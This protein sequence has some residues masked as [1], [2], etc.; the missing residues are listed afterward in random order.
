MGILKLIGWDK[1][2]R[3]LK[4]ETFQARLERHVKVATQLNAL[5][6]EGAIKRAIS[7][8]LKPAN[9]MVTRMLKGSTKAL[10]DSGQLFGS[11]TGVAEKWDRAIIGVLKSRRVKKKGASK[12]SD[13]KQIAAILFYGATITV[14]PKMRRYFY[15]RSQED[16]VR[17]KPIKKTTTVIVI[18]PRPYL[19]AALDKAMIAQYRVNWDAA[20]AKALAGGLG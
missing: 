2:R 19:E 1:L 12:S 16:P 6:A 8:G 7:G 18:P 14:T 3:A 9:A 10:V 17:Y 5:V 13:V 15:A 11:I 4:P 20:I